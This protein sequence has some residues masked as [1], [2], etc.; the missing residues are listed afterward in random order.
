MTDTVLKADLHV[1]S[2]Y[3]T[4]PSE[5]VLRKIGCS[6]SY[7]DPQRIYRIARE[8][9]MHLVTITDHN[10]LAG[11]LEIAHLENTFMSEEITTYFPEDRCKL[12][13]LAYDINENHHEEISSLRE[14]VFDLVRYLDREN[15][16]YALAHPLY[17]I[18]D[19][20]TIHHIE[21]ILLL[22][23]NFEMNG[24]RDG[25]QNGILAQILNSLTKGQLARLGEKHGLVPYDPEPWKKNLIGGSDDHSTMTIARTYTAVED[26]Q[27][28]KGFLKGIAGGRAQPQGKESNPRIMAYNLYSIAYQFYKER[29]HLDRYVMNDLLIQFTDRVLLEDAREEDGFLTR[30]RD[31][32]RRW[33]PLRHFKSSADTISKIF[34]AQARDIVLGN[35]QMFALLKDPGTQEAGRDEVWFQFVNEIS[36]STLKRSADALLEGI[37]GADIFTL[38]Q[39]MGSA[40]SLYALL[41]PYF[42]SYSLFTKDRRFCRKCLARFIKDAQEPDTEDIKVAHFTDTLYEVN[43][44]GKTLLMEALITEKYG[45]AQKIITC[46]DEPDAPGVAHFAPIGTYNMPEYPELKFLYPP[47]LKM[48]DYCYAQNFTHIHAATPGP[49][50]LAALAIARILKL[51]IYGTYHTALPQYASQ[52]TED[53]AMEELMWKYVVWY[54]NQMDVVYVPSLASGAELEA[55]GIIASKI[56]HYPRG[57]DIERFHPSKRNGFF[58]SHFDLQEEE[59][60]ILYVGRISIEKDMPL[61]EEAF[62]KITL[63]R[64]GL[65]LI[66]VGEGPYLEDMQ[67]EMRGLS[68]TFTGYLSGEDLAEAYASCDIFAF[69]SAT[70]TFGN[71]VLEAQASDCHW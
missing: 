71:V 14:N 26:A 35:P 34:K 54:Y 9:G 21:Q 63:Q 20:L 5:W 3:S 38:F 43:G 4:R 69:P 56:R 45:M 6:E 48:L 40:G 44:V 36:G 31:T 8:R 27:S 68:A 17:A 37:S 47:L 18:N 70:D 22:F 42:L 65:R 62:R 33:K 28:V 50:G 19:R 64:S 67:K 57:I 60:K 13:V 52:L 49:I 12:H 29:F 61:L 15:I 24:T 51:P 41:A 16:L 10:T 11:S 25:Y 59:L 55:R 30:L 2:K 39:T 58:Q 1:H 32:L 23:K 7:S 66:V 46:S 53:R